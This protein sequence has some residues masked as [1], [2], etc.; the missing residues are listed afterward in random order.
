VKALILALALGASEL[1]ECLK[2]CDE[3]AKVCTD[4]CAKKSKGNAAFCKPQCNAL[5]GPC[6]KDCNDRNKAK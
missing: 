1:E 3:I 2:S 6:K 4:S 5:A